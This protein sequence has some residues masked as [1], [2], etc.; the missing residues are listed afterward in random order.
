MSDH[1]SKFE[2]FSAGRNSSLSQPNS[3][4]AL[5]ATEWVESERSVWA[6]PGVWGPRTDGGSGL[7]VKAALSDELIVDGKKVDGHAFVR[8]PEENKASTVLFGTNI[9]AGVIGSNGSYGL[10][11]WDSQSDALRRFGHVDAFSYNP[12]WIVR[13]VWREMA[14]AKH[15]FDY[16]RPEGVRKEQEI[17]GRIS[18]DHEGETYSVLAFRAGSALQL[19]FADATTGLTS[20]GVGRFLFI[21]PEPDGAITLDFNYAILPP[22]AFSFAFNCPLPPAQNRFP[23][24]IEAG[25]KNV[26]DLAGELL[27][28]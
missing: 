25:E 11:V 14:G 24:L 26:L 27:H 17:P 10:R 22:C 9:T 21:A 1:R 13:G 18:F 23:F 2:A 15:D 12:D 20:Y 16:L 4:L 7:V 19:V 8:G 28:G 6:I 3:P 5:I